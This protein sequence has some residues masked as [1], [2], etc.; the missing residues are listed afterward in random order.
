MLE[1]LRQDWLLHNMEQFEHSICVCVIGVSEIDLE[2]KEQPMAF[3]GVLIG[4]R[5]TLGV[6]C[7]CFN[8]EHFLKCL[9]RLR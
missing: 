2:V 4:F 1:I 6:P 7:K 5:S 9:C 3:C 8:V